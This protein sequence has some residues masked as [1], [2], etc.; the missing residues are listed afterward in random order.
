MED[1][2]EVPS[3]LKG[4]VALLG[5]PDDLSLEKTPLGAMRAAAVALVDQSGGTDGEAKRAW[6]AGAVDD[7]AKRWTVHYGADVAR[8]PRWDALGAWLAGQECA[9][10]VLM[11][12]FVGPDADAWGPVRKALLDSGVAVIEC[13]RA[14]DR[15]FFSAARAGFF[16]FW[17]KVRPALLPRG[18]AERG[19]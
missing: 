8:L 18:R 9:T 2:P 6:R 4:R 7:A 17:H 10:V 19:T 12:P 3:G 15:R 16:P 1:Y 11:A 13:R 5:H 14:W